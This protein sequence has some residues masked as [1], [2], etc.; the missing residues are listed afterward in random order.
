MTGNLAGYDRTERLHEI[1]IPTLFSCGRVDEAT[2]ETTG[3]YH[4][5]VPRSEIMIY[6]NSAHMPH[7]D[8]PERYI[9]VVSDFMRRNDP[10]KSHDD[11]LS[12]TDFGST[13]YS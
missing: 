11:D 2:P 6:E 3:N 12:L 13:G 7:W 9:E 1:K 5:L 8:E 10:D 4:T